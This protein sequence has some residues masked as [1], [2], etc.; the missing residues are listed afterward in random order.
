MA[1]LNFIHPF[2][3]GNGRAQR[4]FIIELAR[5]AGHR[6]DFSVVSGERMML[7][8]IA[9]HERGE[10]GMMR[11]MFDEISDPPRI[12][13][14]REAIDFLK[15]QK[16]PWNDRYLATTEPGHAVEVTLAGR[17]GARFMARTGSAI[18]VGQTEDLPDPRPDRGENFVLQ[19]TAWPDPA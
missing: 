5:A 14:L 8:S 10:P 3:E 9:A 2:R 15:G 7:A 6:L 13:A 11:R 18:L 12:A 17:G 4:L 1:E 16:Y 19:P